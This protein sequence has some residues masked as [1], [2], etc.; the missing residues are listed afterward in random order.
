MPTISF[1]YAKFTAV[2]TYRANPCAYV[3]D[4]GPAGLGDVILDSITLAGVPFTREEAE[5]LQYGN[6]Q[7]LWDEADHRCWMDAYGPRGLP[8][9]RAIEVEV[10][11][12]ARI[13]E[14]AAA[15]ASA[16]KFK[17]AAE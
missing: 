7:C 17:T 3:R 6:D 4:G 11:D 16:A 1:P 12:A 13:P 9:L 2:A 14:F 10:A 8:D 15:M 5:A